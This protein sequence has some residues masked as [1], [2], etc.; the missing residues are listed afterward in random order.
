MLY[1]V[2]T[3]SEETTDMDKAILLCWLFH[4]VGDI[5][6]PLHCSAMFTPRLFSEGDRGGNSIKVGKYNLHSTWDFV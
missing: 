2:I 4:L 6:Q 1:E 3:K 5:H